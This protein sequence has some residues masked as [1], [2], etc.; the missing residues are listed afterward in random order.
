[1]FQASMSCC[2]VLCFIAVELTDG[3][4]EMVLNKLRDRSS[5]L[6][7]LLDSRFLRRES[8]F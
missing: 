6:L 8:V 4:I 1:M 3:G 5:K 7:T 2:V